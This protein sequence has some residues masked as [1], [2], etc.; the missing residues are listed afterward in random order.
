MISAQFLSQITTF[1]SG[2][3]ILAFNVLQIFLGHI[4]IQITTFSFGPSTL[5]FNVLQL[6][7]GHIFTVGDRKPF[8][9]G[10]M[11]VLEKL[12]ERNDAD[13]LPM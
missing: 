2:S 6:S 11:Y 9:R 8:F 10:Q 4:F 7:L 3:S 13:F 1:C 5:A 12:P